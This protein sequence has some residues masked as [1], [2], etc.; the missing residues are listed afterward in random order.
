MSGVI[1]TLL[2]VL[3]YVVLNSTSVYSRKKWQQGLESTKP[4]EL[5]SGYFVL[6]VKSHQTAYQVVS[7]FFQSLVCNRTNANRSSNKEWFAQVVSLILSFL[8][9]PVPSTASYWNWW[10]SLVIRIQVWQE[11]TGKCHN[12][13]DWNLRSV[14]RL[15]VSWGAFLSKAET[16]SCK[17]PTSCSVDQEI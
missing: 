9:V 11:R 1:P 6:S 12:L 7:P 8:M 17:S 4:L 16:G 5:P 14:G 15:N 13:V 3:Y 10:W 2:H